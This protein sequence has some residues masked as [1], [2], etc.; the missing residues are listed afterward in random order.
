M[1]EKYVCST[2]RSFSSE[3]TPILCKDKRL[4]DPLRR[5]GHGL[6]PASTGECS[7]YSKGIATLYDEQ[8]AELSLALAI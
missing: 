7:G 8:V 3:G 2:S 4:D 6:S 5:S 1:R